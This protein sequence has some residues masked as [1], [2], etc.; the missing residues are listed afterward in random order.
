MSA[1]DATL[2]RFSGITVGNYKCR[3]CAGTRSG[4]E[5][6]P[7][8]TLIFLLRGSFRH[9]TFRQSHLLTSEY[10]LFKKPR[11]EYEAIHE[12]YIND[13]CFY[14]EFDDNVL[15]QL[16]YSFST[17]ILDFLK[18]KDQSSILLK[19]NPSVSYTTWLLHRGTNDA[20]T[21]LEFQSAILQL[22]TTVL[23]QA[24]NPSSADRSL[25]DSVD[26]AKQFIAE[27]FSEDISLED[28]A[29]ASHISP[30]HFSRVFKYNTNFSP[31]QFLL[32]VRLFNARKMLLNTTLNVSDVGYSSGFSNPDYFLT[33]FKKKHG[34]T[35]SE[36][37]KSSC[38]APSLN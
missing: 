15:D 19:N 33:V 21:S 25:H 34:V 12:H 6:T 7:V 4:V 35:P 3:A 17:V 24:S 10:I 36:F 5:Y 13:Y 2:Q 30:F 9:T 29:A 22:I 14:I 38:R 16:A 37:R 32:D 8:Y 11:F 28:V 20:I 31:H 1:I 18:N 23:G 26:K 27:N